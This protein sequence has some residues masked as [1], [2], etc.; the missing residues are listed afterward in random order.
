VRALNFVVWSGLLTACV[1][2]WI[3]LLGCIS[4]WVQP[5]TATIDSHSWQ[6]HLPAQAWAGV[7]PDLERIAV[8][9]ISPPDLA[10]L[11]V[12][13]HKRRQ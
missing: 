2:F 6:I 11:I 13:I 12:E 7:P 3:W 5:D 10:G 1:V 4:A 9:V 8:R